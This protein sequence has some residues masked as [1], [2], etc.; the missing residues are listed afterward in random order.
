VLLI[1]Y[2]G[3]LREKLPTKSHKSVVIPVEF[4]STD[5]MLGC[6]VH[7]VNKQNNSRLLKTTLWC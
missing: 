5:E 3:K 6:R 1:I 7:A 4:H 2:A